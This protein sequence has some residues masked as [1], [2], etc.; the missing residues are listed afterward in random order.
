MVWTRG[1]LE[2][3][4]G[5]VRASARSRPPG[6]LDIQMSR[7]TGTQPVGPIPLDTME[8]GM[9]SFVGNDCP[10]EVSE[11]WWSGRVRAS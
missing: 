3:F 11:D 6:A 7:G 1:Q 10:G 5:G 9:G 8:R 4:R 2:A